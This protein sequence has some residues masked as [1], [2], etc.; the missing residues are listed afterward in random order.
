MPSFCL[1]FFFKGRFHLA[2]TKLHRLGPSVRCGNDSMTLHI[3]GAI[4]TP[5]FLVDRGK[6]F[7]GCAWVEGVPLF[8]FF[9]KFIY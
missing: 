9:F 1:F 6:L 7:W 5:H 3:P 4:R 8:F 2:K